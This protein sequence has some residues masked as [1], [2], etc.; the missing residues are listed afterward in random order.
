MTHQERFNKIFTFQ[1]VDRIPC[2]FFGSWN[3]TKQRWKNEGFNAELIFGDPGPQLPGMDPD[4]ESGMWN[5]QGLVIT[6]CIGDI[7]TKV[8]EEDDTRRVIRNSIDEEI[9]ERKDGTSIPHT[10]LHALEP[11]RKSWESFKRFLDP[12]DPRRRPSGWEEKAKIF[13]KRDVVRTFMGG[14]LYG[15]LRNWMGVENIS[16]L[17]YDDPILFEEMV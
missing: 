1:K 6:G 11:T 17:M 8:L 7:E 15:L 3:E 16:Y 10:R 13:N 5:K 9:I 14:S 12:I 2:Y 4:W